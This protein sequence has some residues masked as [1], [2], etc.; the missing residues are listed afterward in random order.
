VS[1]S[2]AEQSKGS[3]LHRET[4]L[5]KRAIIRLSA[6]ATRRDGWMGV[7]RLTQQL[8]QNE[9][10]ERASEQEREREVR[11]ALCADDGF[12]F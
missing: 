7:A 5:A 3:S 9:M 1:E 4:R 8:R 10:R 12:A 2:R 11:S 6:A